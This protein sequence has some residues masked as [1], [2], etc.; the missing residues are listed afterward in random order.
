ML[1]AR[2]YLEDRLRVKNIHSMVLGV[3]ES[4]GSISL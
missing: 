2:I 4:P 3:G 1:P